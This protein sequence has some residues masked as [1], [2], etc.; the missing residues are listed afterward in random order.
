MMKFA[1]GMWMLRPGVTALHPVAVDSVVTSEDALTVYATTVPVRGRGDTLNRALLTFTYTAVADGVIRVRAAHLGGGQPRRPAY[2]ISAPP[3]HE[4]QGP[5]T[6]WLPPLTS[7]DSQP[8]AEVTDEVARLTAG[9]LTV[10]VALTGEW[11]VSF[12]QD[13]TPV[14]TSPA[15]GCAFL[16]VVPGGV[17]AGATVTGGPAASGAFVREQLSLGVGERIYGLGE[18][19]GPFV[20]N[21]QSVDSWN[22]DGGTSSDQAYKSVPF[23]LSSAGY[24]VFVAHPERVSFEVGTEAVEAVQFSVEGQVLEYYVI[25]GPTPKAVLAR[26]TALTGRAPRLPAWSYGTWLSTSFTTSYD[27]A[28]VMAALDGMA[29]HGLPVSVFHFDCF[30]MREYQ[31]CDFTWDP[32]VFPDPASMLARLHARGLKVCVWINPY[33]AERSPLFAEGAARGYLLKTTSGDVW[34]T[35]LWQAGM[36]IIDLT[37]PAARA[38]WLSQLEALLDAGVDTLKT[39]FGERIPAHDVA[40]FDGSEPAKMHNWYAGLY[41]GAVFDLLTRKRGEGEAVV[42]A[43]AATAGGQRYPVHWGGDSWSTFVSMAETLRGG[44]SL[45]LSGFAYW[46][47]DIGGFE[48][49]PDP[50]VFTRWLAFGLLSSH[51]RF[52]GSGSMRLPWL[53]GEAAVAATRRFSELKMRLMPY[54]A[55]GARE[56]VATGVPLLRPLVLEFPDD[57]TAR[58]VD[59]QYLLGPSLL[60]APVFTKE[61]TVEFYLPAG[62]WTSLLDGTVAEGGRWVRET[63]DLA[64]LPLYV[65]EDTVLPLGAAVDRPESDWA[66]GVTLDLY[67]LVDGHDS[68]TVIPAADAGVGASDVTFRVRRAGDVITVD[69]DSDRAWAIRVGGVTSTYPA[70]TQMVQLDV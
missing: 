34:Q 6:R 12:V 57:R 2:E 49:T 68:T 44:L 35:D 37:N 64:S 39:D 59:T 13:G 43:R 29:E 27:E 36:G 62:R 11:R 56:A 30:W 16:Q 26:Y 61:G 55:A 66:D 47:H 20:K 7:A 40:W 31:W 28:T 1:D 4:P 58:E 32:R 42:F 25:A 24:G 22:E 9:S 45:A 60:V 8:V 18:R 38:W 50:D 69:T 10:E 14:V 21:G 3:E 5:P 67:E 33:I 48:G 65:R 23:Y 19:F 51:S 41:N 46:S 52:H 54:L 53:Y 63:H 70:G 17:P 15:K